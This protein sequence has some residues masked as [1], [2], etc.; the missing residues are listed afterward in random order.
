MSFSRVG[1]GLSH[2][3]LQCAN[4]RFLSSLCLALAELRKEVEK[5]GEELIGAWELGVSIPY[6]TYHRQEFFLN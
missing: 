6:K 5:E 1:D 3:D 2:T 4:M